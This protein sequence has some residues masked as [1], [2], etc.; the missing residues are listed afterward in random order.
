MVEQKEL[1]HSFG[2]KDKSKGMAHNVWVRMPALTSPYRTL[3]VPPP[4]QPR[5]H[6]RSERS[7]APLVVSL[8]A[9]WWPSGHHQVAALQTPIQFGV[10]RGC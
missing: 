7:E 4:Q 2:D 3:C 6:P 1:H 8:L 9:P 10:V 5:G